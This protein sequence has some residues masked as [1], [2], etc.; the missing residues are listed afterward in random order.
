MQGEGRGRRCRDGRSIGDGHVQQP[1]VPVHFANGVG[2]A[3]L[4]DAV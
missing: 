4:E 1:V 3:V 2:C